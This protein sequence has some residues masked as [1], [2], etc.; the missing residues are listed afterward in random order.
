MA[1]GLVRCIMQGAAEAAH[2][3]PS[4]AIKSLKIYLRSMRSRRQVAMNSHMKLN[5][6]CRSK[7]FS[8]MQHLL[9]LRDGTRYC[10][11]VTTPAGARTPVVFT[12]AQV[13]GFQNAEFGVCSIIPMVIH[14]LLRS[15]STRC[16]Q[17]M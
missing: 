11:M 13:A 6:V 9:L 7:S 15:R 8:A 2:G 3:D 14:R 16:R 17:C 5:P 1:I 12:A 4:R 10:R